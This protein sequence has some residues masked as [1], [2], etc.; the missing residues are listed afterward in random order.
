MDQLSQRL[1]LRQK[2]RY[3]MS[4]SKVKNNK[5]KNIWIV[6]YRVNGKRSKR[7]KRVFL[8]ELDARSCE[9]NHLMEKHRMRFAGPDSLSIGKDIA[10]REEA[11][12]WLNSERHRFSESYQRTV[13]HFLKKLDPQ[14]GH[15]K[16]EQLSQAQLS[17]IQ[18]ELLARGLK[19]ASANRY[20]QVILAILNFS[21]RHR[22][23]PMNPASGFQKLKESHEAVGFWEREE[24]ESFLDFASRKYPLSS[25][26]RWVYVAY[27][28]AINTGARAG[29]I[30]ALKPTDVDQ[31]LLLIERQFSS[32][33]GDFS[34]T[35][36]KK[37][38]RVPCNS[39]LLPEL[40]ALISNNRIKDYE[41]IF[42]TEN[43]HPI[44][45]DNFVKRSFA[46]DVREWGGRRIRFHDLRHTAT[47]LMIG[48]GVD[49]KTVQ[50]ICGHDNI[51]T[52]MNY[53]H[54]LSERIR[55]TARTFSVRPRALEPTSPSAPT[56]TVIQGGRGTMESLPHQPV[57]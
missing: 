16:L 49:L 33:A 21:V 26:K 44:S 5:G 15:L 56:L 8:S 27:L 34:K 52:T 14:I 50:E 29:E 45:H 18:R 55:E 25:T 24:A 10:F 47:S 2:E 9:Q 57:F 22:R 11:E 19:A 54:L 46:K 38:R 37:F 42:Q 7:V 41:T 36:G 30:W 53:I 43:R 1:A 51:K 31:D 13:T 48:S 32:A 3:S 12:N 4:I 39:I 17:R 23:I 20:I 35:K 40:N 28:T 6:R